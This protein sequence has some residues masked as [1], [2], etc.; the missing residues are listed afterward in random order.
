MAGL[1]GLH[2]VNREGAD[3]IDR[4]LNHFVVSHGILLSGSSGDS[5]ADKFVRYSFAAAARSASTNAFSWWTRLA[6]IEASAARKRGNMATFS[7]PVTTQRM[8]R[9]RLS[10]GY[11]N[12][13]RRRFI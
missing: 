13:M 10:I 1:G 5:N 2:R 12:V 11:V 7:A 6:G 9:E 8:R 3:S 4:E